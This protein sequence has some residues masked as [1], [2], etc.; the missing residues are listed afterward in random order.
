M[1]TCDRLHERSEVDLLA[2]LIWAEARGETTQGK[3]A[4][5]HVVLNRMKAQSYFGSTI[6]DV[7]LKPGHFSSFNQDGT[8]R[9]RLPS[10][11]PNDREFALC[12]AIAELAVH[13]HLKDDPTGGATHFHRNDRKPTWA[14]KLT[15]LGQIGKHVFYRESLQP[16]LTASRDANRQKPVREI[17]L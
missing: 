6:S 1:E 14:S 11:S 5:A 4:V 12:K 10:V 16:A 7:I 9:T 8:N 13:G 3:R 17:Q 15:Y 2:H